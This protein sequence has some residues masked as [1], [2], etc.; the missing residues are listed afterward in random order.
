MKKIVLSALLLTL[1]LNAMAQKKEAYPFYYPCRAE[2]DGQWGYVDE[3]NDWVVS[4]RYDALL[5]E[6][7]G[8]MYPVSKNGK[9]GFV[10]VSGEMLTDIKFDA[11]V[12][13]ID[14]QKAGYPV[15]FAAVRLR[16]KWAFINVQGRFVTGFN[17]DEVLIMNGKY[18]I[19]QKTESGKMRTGHLDRDGKEV[20]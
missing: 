1:G 17:Y 4:P 10:G 9:W 2:E 5:Y 3:Q 12:C 6:T 13:E 14:Y 8:G 19:R 18:I 16:G 11:V 15:N 20:W 7:N